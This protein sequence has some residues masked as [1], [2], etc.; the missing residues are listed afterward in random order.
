MASSSTFRDGSREGSV[1]SS[2]NTTFNDEEQTQPHQ[3]NPPADT[4]SRAEQFRKDLGRPNIHQGLHAQDVLREYGMPS[5]V[6]VLQAEDKHRGFKQ[7]ILGTN[8][9]R[10]ERDLLLKEN[11]RQTTRNIVIASAFIFEG[12]KI[13]RSSD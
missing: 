6:N 8:Q 5:N 7:D 4:I 1:A 10:P 11:F 3:I 13:S 9:Q 12:C 2:V